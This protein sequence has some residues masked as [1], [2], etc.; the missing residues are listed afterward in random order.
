MTKRAIV[1]M[2][3]GVD[4]SAAA[5]LALEQGYDVMGVT[6]RLC[7]AAPEGAA[8][9]CEKL[10]VPFEVWDARDE[11]HRRVIEPFCA[12]YRAGKTPNPCVLCNRAMKFGFLM[13][14]AKEL[15]FDA[16]F[17]GHYA[18][19]E[20]HDGRFQLKK[21]L[22]EKKDQSYVLSQL[23]QVQLSKLRLP[24]GGMTKSEVRAL[25]E[26]AG[27]KS[28]VSAKE[29]QDICF[30]PDGDYCS[31]V[32]RE[33]GTLTPGLFQTEDGR[34]IGPHRG[35]ER[36]TVGQR[37]GLGVAWEYPLYVLSKDAQTGAVTLGPQER[38]YQSALSAGEM[39]WIAID[40]PEK[41]FRALARTRYHQ[42][43]TP[44]TVTPLSEGKA[45]AVFDRPVRAP[46][47]GQTVVFY[48][49]ELV[50]GGGTIL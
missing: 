21:G 38:V 44:C 48:D 14:K 25:A 27:F 31:F 18:R 30:I 2:S 35:L 26:K 20:E 28:A 9:I 7:G 45:E 13:Q 46:A 29:S 12:A 19:V 1:A 15:G 23:T 10:R 24:L 5:L 39:N 41:P 11:F 32:E 4:S 50:L 47:P 43:E 22:D 49:G 40:T 17:S 8:A 37:R 36:Y 16:V 42:T 33:A 3:G 6:L 34:V